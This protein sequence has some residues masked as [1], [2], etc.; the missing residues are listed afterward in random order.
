MGHKC[1][2][3][4]FSVWLLAKHSE[5]CC[6]EG[7][8]VYKGTIHLWFL[9]HLP[10]RSV[11]TEVI[12]HRWRKIL[13][14]DLLW[15]WQ[16]RAWQPWLPCQPWLQHKC[17]NWLMIRLCDVFFSTAVGIFAKR[18]K[19]LGIDQLLFIL[20]SFHC[21]DRLFK[22]L[23]VVQLDCIL[24]HIARWSIS[25]TIFVHSI[26]GLTSFKLEITSV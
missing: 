3:Y 20:N 4:F 18:D 13:F 21:T 12:E 1:P 17:T 25:N 22:E 10:F 6:L 15:A 8:C 11:S 9:L 19:L 14:F 24:L 23:Y 26:F 2:I 16:P 5:L 7:V